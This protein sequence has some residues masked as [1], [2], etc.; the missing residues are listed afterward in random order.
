MQE[1]NLLSSMNTSFSQ[2]LQHLSS[3]NTITLSHK[4]THDTVEAWQLEYFP[5]C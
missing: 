1:V 3:E 2:Y 5:F 4:N